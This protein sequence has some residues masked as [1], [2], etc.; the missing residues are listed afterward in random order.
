MSELKKEVKKPGRNLLLGNMLF[1]H[2]EKAKS[3]LANDHD[4]VSF[5]IG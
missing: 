4:Y 2:L 3:N 5:K 1:K